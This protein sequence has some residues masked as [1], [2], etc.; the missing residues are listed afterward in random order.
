MW[1]NSEVPEFRGGWTVIKCAYMISCLCFRKATTPGPILGTRFHTVF[2]EVLPTYLKRL[3]VSLC[4]VSSNNVSC[5]G[6]FK[7]TEAP[8]IPPSAWPPRRMKSANWIAWT[9]NQFSGIGTREKLKTMR[10]SRLS[11]NF[12]KLPQVNWCP[13]LKTYESYLLDLFQTSNFYWLHHLFCSHLIFAV[14]RWNYE[15][16]WK[17]MYPLHPCQ[18]LKLCVMCGIALL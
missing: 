10:V 6:S 16:N 2:K 7:G 17:A 4:N 12:V 15:L 3:L 8:R 1:K 13:L 11:P 5:I 9:W 18:T 14:L